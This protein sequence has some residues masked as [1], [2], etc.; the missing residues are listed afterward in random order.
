MADKHIA[1]RAIDHLKQEIGDEGLQR[2]KMIDDL[3][4]KHVNSYY[5]RYN[6]DPTKW[7]YGE[8]E[9]MD[10]EAEGLVDTLTPPHLRKAFDT[11]YELEATGRSQDSATT[12]RALRQQYPEFVA[13]MERGQVQPIEEPRAI[14]KQ[15]AQQ[16]APATQPKPAT[17]MPVRKTEV[18][19]ALP[20]QTAQKPVQVM[21][22][23]QRKTD[24]LEQRVTGFFSGLEKEGYWKTPTQD[25]IDKQIAQERLRNM[26][27][28]QKRKAQERPI[29]PVSLPEDVE[30]TQE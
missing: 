8:R 15:P 18:A 13:R 6:S 9:R 22:P 21:P 24:N 14:T 17:I 1:D 2:Y 16:Y 29:E 23:R 25:D 20:K 10:R 7:P 26:M 28:E 12:E 4:R 5:E 3:V 27:Y 11:L 30:R 19:P